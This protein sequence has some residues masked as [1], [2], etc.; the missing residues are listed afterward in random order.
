MLLERKN[1]DILWNKNKI[2]LKKASSI[3]NER[4]NVDIYTY[5][6][7]IQPSRRTDFCHL[8]KIDEDENHHGK[9]SK[10]E[11]KRKR[12]HMFSTRQNMDLKNNMKLKMEL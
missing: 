5:W 10:P 6:T 3:W 11:S 2:P 12:S 1:L 9:L 7:F 4:E 8:W